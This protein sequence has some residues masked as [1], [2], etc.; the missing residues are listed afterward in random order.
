MQQPTSP[1]S[2]SPSRNLHF[3]TTMSPE[4]PVFINTGPYDP[5]QNQVDPLDRSWLLYDQGSAT[6]APATVQVAQPP[7]ERQHSTSASY[8]SLYTPDLP[9]YTTTPSISHSTPSLDLLSPDLLSTPRSPLHHH[10]HSYILQD[11]RTC[12]PGFDLFRQFTSS[13]RI[14]YP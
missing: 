1:I 5:D 13:P 6:N 9:Y 2:H 4:T 14:L 12:R 10:K 7:L 11:K 3:P 8:A